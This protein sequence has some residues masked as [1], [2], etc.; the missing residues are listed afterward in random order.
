MT[1]LA[2]TSGPAP[3]AS[4]PLWTATA[5]SLVAHAALL[6][7]LGSLVTTAWRSDGAAPV[8]GS[9]IPL[10]AW[11]VPRAPEPEAPRI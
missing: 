4:R 9:G 2:T 6:A 3:A 7:A 8:P 10:Q 1:T 11:L 5:L